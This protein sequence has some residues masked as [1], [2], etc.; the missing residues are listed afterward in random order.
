MSKRNQIVPPTP[1]TPEVV[2]PTPQL[3]VLSP[4][5]LAH[6]F[7]AGSQR[8]VWFASLAAMQGKPLADWLTA[9]AVSPPMQ[10]QKVDHKSP[11][12]GG[13]GFLRRFRKLDLLGWGAT[14]EEAAATSEGDS[15][16]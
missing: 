3:I 4:K 1:A 9:V 8:A 7:R 12:K 6:Q 11:H 5:G 16:E 2:A 10:R 13:Q 14:A 15:A